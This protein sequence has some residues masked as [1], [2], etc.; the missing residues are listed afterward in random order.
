MLIRQRVTATPCHRPITVQQRN[1]SQSPGTWLIHTAASR[2]P[3]ELG[4]S[5]PGRDGWG[6]CS[7]RQHQTWTKLHGRS[8]P[9]LGRLCPGQTT[10]DHT[11]DLPT[12][13]NRHCTYVHT[14]WCIKRRN[15]HGA[16]RPSHQTVQETVSRNHCSERWQCWIPCSTWQPFTAMNEANHFRNCLTA[17]CTCT[18]T[19]HFMHNLVHM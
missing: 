7:L 9:S 16:W 18:R 5:G 4:R 19:F 11:A 12:H 8:H 1:T 10:K 14:G 2:S 17:Q 15:I 3:G 13:H 6:I